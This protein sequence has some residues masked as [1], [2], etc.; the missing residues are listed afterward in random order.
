MDLSKNAARKGASHPERLTLSHPRRTSLKH[1]V[2]R[3]MTN[4]EKGKTLSGI[5]P[6]AEL[7]AKMARFYDLKLNPQAKKVIKND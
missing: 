2:V 7:L 6:G 4:K 5:T 1:E 3:D